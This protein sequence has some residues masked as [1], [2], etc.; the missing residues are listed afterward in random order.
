MG[1]W[2]ENCVGCGNRHDAALW[3]YRDVETEQREYLCGVKYSEVKDK[4]AWQLLEP[5]NY[6]TTRLFNF[7]PSSI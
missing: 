4:S 7:Q 6:D 3:Y 1:Y 2:E 5:P